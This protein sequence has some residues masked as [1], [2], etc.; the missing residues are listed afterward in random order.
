[1]KNKKSVYYF[2]KILYNNF[3]DVMQVL[4]FFIC[5]TK[6]FLQVV[7]LIKIF[8]NILRFVIPIILIVMLVLDLLKNVIN[9]NEKEGMKKIYTRVI[10]AVIVF[11]VP[12]IINLIMSLI[13]DVNGTNYDYS[14]S[15]CYVNA[16]SSCIENIDNYLNCADVSDADTE[17]K[18]ACKKYRQCNDYKL[19]S[20][21]SITTEENNSDCQNE[22]GYFKT[23]YNYT[24]N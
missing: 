4:D 13:N 2:L 19:S 17:A 21:C 9:P 6:G 24:G 22:N 15:N 12:T 18:K 1:M 8:L 16:N 11:L 14:I 7:N 10:A 5:D 20:N 3:G 23:D